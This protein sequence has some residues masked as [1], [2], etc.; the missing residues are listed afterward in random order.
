[1]SGRKNLS[2]SLLASYNLYSTVTFPTRIATNTSTLIDNIYIDIYNCKFT[3]HPLINGL[4]DHDAQV[5]KLSNLL[6]SNPTSHYTL[7]RRI[8]S[9]TIQTF[10]YGLSYE[11][12]QEVFVEEDVNKTFNTF[13]NTYLRIVNASFP[14]VYRKKLTNSNPW[15]TTGIKISC[16][17]KRSLY[18][19]CRNSSN[20]KYKAHYKEYCKIL[21]DVIRAAKK[22]CTLTH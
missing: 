10:M 12:W 9:N 14:V 8:D 19:T 4:S 15:I 20:P 13:F 21:S 7:T 1:M 22:K 6:I 2:E 3:V 11:N 17:T 5:I 16:N 18:K